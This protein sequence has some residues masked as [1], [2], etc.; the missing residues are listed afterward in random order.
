MFY[1]R[2]AFNLV[3]GKYLEIIYCKSA[4]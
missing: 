3:I 1:K 4:S 2:T